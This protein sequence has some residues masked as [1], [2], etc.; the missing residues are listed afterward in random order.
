[1]FNYYEHCNFAVYDPA[2]VSDLAIT[3][4]FPFGM[5]IGII[6]RTRRLKTDAMVRE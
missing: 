5:P 4:Y 2:Y 6:V 1:V 3:A